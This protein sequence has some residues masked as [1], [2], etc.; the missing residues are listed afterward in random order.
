MNLCNQTYNHQKLK[1]IVERIH[2]DQAVFKVIDETD[3]KWQE[4]VNEDS[5]VKTFLTNLGESNNSEG[6]RGTFEDVGNGMVQLLLS[7]L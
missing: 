6:V 5:A 1:N 7:L 4:S 2:N 3:C